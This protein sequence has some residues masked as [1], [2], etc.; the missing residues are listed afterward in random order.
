MDL[1]VQ[2]SDGGKYLWKKPGQEKIGLEAVTEE[3]QKST[4][5]LNKA[6]DMRKQGRKEHPSG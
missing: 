3:G 6:K 5:H 4:L 1:S 2:N